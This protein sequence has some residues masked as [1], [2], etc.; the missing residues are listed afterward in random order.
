M[1][2]QLCFK[3]NRK[4]DE[5]E[6]E[7]RKKAAYFRI[8]YRPFTQFEKLLKLKKVN[9]GEDL[10]QYNVNNKPCKTFYI[11]LMNRKEA[12]VCALENAGI[13]WKIS[14]VNFTADGTSV[15]FGCGA[16]VC[17]LLQQNLRHLVSIHRVGHR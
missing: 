17:K 13:A 3:T 5:V 7:K 15:N 16:G 14:L 11:S 12:I 9:F 2:H 4:M 8:F 6:L 1:W 10:S